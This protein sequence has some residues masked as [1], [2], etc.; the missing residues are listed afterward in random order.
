MQKDAAA[1]KPTV[2][3]LSGLQLTTAVVV[4]R[5]VNCIGDV[6][7]LGDVDGVC[8]L[9]TRTP[10]AGSN[11]G[12]FMTSRSSASRGVTMPVT[13]LP[14]LA[15]SSDAADDDDGAICDCVLLLQL[16]VVT[17]FL[18]SFIGIIAGEATAT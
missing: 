11:F 9:I 10:P 8:G 3:T 13:S 16:L 6:I 1:L 12:P 2:R 4:R 7:T 5:V 18:T 14:L 15:T 17:K